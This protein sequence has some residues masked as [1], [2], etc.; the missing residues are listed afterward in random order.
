MWTDPLT[1]YANISTT[2]R[3][4]VGV[5]AEVDDANI[6][7]EHNLTIY[8]PFSQGP[9]FGACLLVRAIKDQTALVPAIAKTIRAV[10]ATQPVEH[11][12]TL[13]EVRTE[14]LGNDRVTAIYTEDSRSSR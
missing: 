4:I 3:R 7:P 1:K 13:E 10:A 5:L 2:G 12:N 6:V 9:L 8:Q 11:P 14:V